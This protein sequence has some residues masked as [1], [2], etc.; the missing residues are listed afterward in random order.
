MIT[1]ASVYT[2]YC[3]HP[4]IKPKNHVGTIYS[5]SENIIREHYIAV[6]QVALTGGK[7]YSDP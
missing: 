1:T 6:A 4:K 3:N 2:V 5:D 7:R